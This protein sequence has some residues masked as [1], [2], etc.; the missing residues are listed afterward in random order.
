MMTATLLPIVP[1]LSLAP[2]AQHAP[3]QEGGDQG[4]NQ[5]RD[6]E[7]VHAGEHRRAGPERQFSL[8]GGVPNLSDSGD[9]PI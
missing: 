2:L 8:W 3:D 6:A 7:I 9:S 5:G 1:A 4:D